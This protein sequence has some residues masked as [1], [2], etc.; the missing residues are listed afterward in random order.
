MI[1]IVEDDLVIARHLEEGLRRHGLVTTHCVKGQQALDHLSHEVAEVILL[2]ITLPDMT[3]FEILEKL[4][5]KGNQT[6]VIML[7]A[8]DS[9]ADKVRGLD[10]GADDYITKPFALEEV[11]SR[12]KAVRRR[13]GAETATTIEEGPLHIDLVARSVSYGGKQLS[14]TD[15]EFKILETLVMSKGRVM[16]RSVLGEKIW[17]L[18][19]AMRSNL[20]DSHIRNLRSKFDA[21]NRKAPIR[22]VKGY[23]YAFE[24]DVT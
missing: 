24:R 21:V 14:L 2:D 22:T 1:L 3:G 16:T 17:G 9:V 10:S 18:D 12:L 6:P 13:Q 23:G 7:T 20:I 4:R 11:L 8:R 19:H 15:T 5:R